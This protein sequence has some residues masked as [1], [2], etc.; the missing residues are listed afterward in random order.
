M[1]TLPVACEYCGMWLHSEKEHEQHIKTEHPLMSN[2]T[3]PL[4]YT[5]KV[6]KLGFFNEHTT[7]LELECK[8]GSYC[9]LYVLNEDIPQGVKL[10]QP[11]D[12][13]IKL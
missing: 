9:V 5:G 1:N 3:K 2:Y 7:K 10:G 4:S 11:V 6:M 13:L 12:L 8:D